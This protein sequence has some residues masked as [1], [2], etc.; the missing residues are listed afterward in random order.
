MAWAWSPSRSRP[1]PTLT[2]FHSFTWLF[3]IE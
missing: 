1:G 2:E 3:H